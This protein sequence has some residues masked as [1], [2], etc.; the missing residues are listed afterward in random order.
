MT[1]V[2]KTDRNPTRVY[3]R[4]DR[5]EIVAITIVSWY[6]PTVQCKCP[7]RLKGA[8]KT[9]AATKD[10]ILT[11]AKQLYAANGYDRTMGRRIS[12]LAGCNASTINL[13]FCSVKD[14]YVEV[15]R[16]AH[17]ELLA[18]ARLRALLDQPRQRNARLHGLIDILAQV[19]VED[20]SVVWAMRITCREQLWGSS[21]SPTIA[22]T[23]KFPWERLLVT[24][25]AESLGVSSDHPAV[26]PGC[27]AILGPFALLLLGNE[28]SVNRLANHSIDRNALDN[29]VAYFKRFVIA[30]LVDSRSRLPSTD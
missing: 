10:R 17:Q 5:K 21:F 26:A 24:S 11:A 30:G 23:D 8:R 12:A 6:F 18:H 29:L 15:L 28:I 27:L 25:V 16:Q 13:Y 22:E 4:L 7:R 1:R 20:P 2:A 14:L 9:G 3:S 19:L